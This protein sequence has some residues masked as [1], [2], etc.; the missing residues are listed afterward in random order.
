M[1]DDRGEPS[2]LANI[3]RLQLSWRRGAGVF[4]LSGAAIL[5]AG[6]V[7]SSGPL[8]YRDASRPVEER[9]ADLLGRMTLEEK[10]GQMTQADHSFIKNDEDVTRYL[11]GSVLSGGDSEP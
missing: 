4:W 8:P 9:V 6:T 5:A 1:L 3:M 2:Y 10:V 7:G 11:L